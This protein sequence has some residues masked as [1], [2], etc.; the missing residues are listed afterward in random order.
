MGV[1]GVAIFS[2]DLAADIRDDFR[3]LIGEGLTV[4]D[5]VDRLLTEF[6]PRGDEIPIF[7]I[8]L[9][10]IQWKVG[11]LEKRTKV[12]AIRVI[13]TEEDL[14]K[15]DI[16]KEREKRKL[17]LQKLREQLLTPPPP[18]KRIPRRLKSSSDWN[19]GEVIGYQLKSGN[20][21]LM[22]VVGHHSDKGGRD[23][24]CELLDW[25]G[26]ELPDSQAISRLVVRYGQRHRVSQFLFQEPRKKLDHARVRR[27][28]ITSAPVQKCGGYTVFVWPH[29][30]RQMKDC[31]GL[32]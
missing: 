1:W 18:P 15:W 12:E 8:S 28:G 29:V 11:R 2:D 20:W 16:P 19:V 4:S 21:A 23:A 7:W 5:A 3:D 10:A 9:A 31:Y 13:D 14:E 30:D 26:T 17:V 22:R 25:T 24:V 32:T 27:L 6:D